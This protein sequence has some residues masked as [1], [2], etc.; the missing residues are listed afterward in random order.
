M[1]L[2]SGSI[3]NVT[4]DLR[5]NSKTFLRKFV[6]NFDSKKNEALLI[7]AGCA[8]AFL[9]LENNSI[10]HYYMDSYFENNIKSNYL[11]LRY[12]DEIFKIKWPFKPKIISNTDKNYPRL[13]LKSI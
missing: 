10:I 2:I 5:K 13:D 9:T 11:G 6:Y 1:N 3:Y 8:N 12:D 7:P 4:I